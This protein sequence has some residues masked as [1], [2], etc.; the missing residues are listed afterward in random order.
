M[1]NFRLVR[2]LWQFLAVAEELH[3]GRAAKR[4][5]ISQPP[6]TE[7]IQVLEN[8]LRVKL[9][10]RSRRGTQLTPEGAAI[11]PVVQRLAAQLEAVEVAV[12]EAI[13]GQRGMLTIGAVT[14]ALSET[15]PDLIDQLSSRFPNVTV[16]VRE[17]D[18]AEAV[19]ALQEGRID[20]AFARLEAQ[21]QAAVR[22][23]PL[24]EDRLVVALHQSHPLAKLRRVSLRQLSDEPVVMFG[25]NLNPVLFDSVL[26]ACHEH[27]YSPR[28]VHE[29]RS[30]ATQI[31]LVACGQGVALVPGTLEALA[32]K[33]VILKP[34]KEAIHV[35]T[36]A[37]AW[38]ENR[39]NPLVDAALELLAI[40]SSKRIQ[41]NKR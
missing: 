15:V 28:V 16:Q 34:L 37:V 10:I 1:I 4:L 12:R 17:I 31:A 9:F 38:N 22:V 2:H 33:K 36:T 18:S 32:S 8:A 23:Q 21:S 24:S 39:P 3:F 11:L 20:L 14:F 7:Q 41:Q 30:I 19:T 29:V 13:A 25:R 27:A 6:L 5:G 26:A 40:D 35:V